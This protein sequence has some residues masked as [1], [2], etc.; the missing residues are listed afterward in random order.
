MLAYRRGP[1]LPFDATAVRTEVPFMLD[2]TVY[3]DALKPPELPPPV[4]R[5]LS[6]T[7]SCIVRSRAPKAWSVPGTAIWPIQGR[8]RT[9]HRQSTLRLRGSFGYHTVMVL[10]V[11][12]A[13]IA[14]RAAIGG[15]DKPGHDGR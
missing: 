11:V 4:R 12:P 2:T 8:L 13:T 15:P 7:S 14:C 1:G 9:A 5:W 10:L 6:G 3:I